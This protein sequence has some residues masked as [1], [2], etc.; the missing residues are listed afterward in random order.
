MSC[1]GPR[2]KTKKGLNPDDFG[3]PDRAQ[4]ET[5]KGSAKTGSKFGI[6]ATKTSPGLLTPDAAVKKSGI[7]TRSRASSVGS[8]SQTATSPAS[9]PRSSLDPKGTTSTKTVKKTASVNSLRSVTGA[10][11][12]GRGGRTPS[13]TPAAAKASHART[14]STASTKKSPIAQMREDFD[15]LKQKSLLAAQASELE[16]LRA[17]L[18]SPSS[19]TLSVDDGQVVVGKEEYAKLKALSEGTMQTIAEKDAILQAREQEL[20]D[21]RIRLEAERNEAASGDVP[22]IVVS[23]Q[24]DPVKELKER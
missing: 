21:L 8:G 14:P 10:T 24:E 19:S 6:K 20:E 13:P 22:T 15:D 12:N 1:M 11:A 2:K 4:T 23:E 5:P 3:G 18:L 16:A 9:S 7:P 17:K